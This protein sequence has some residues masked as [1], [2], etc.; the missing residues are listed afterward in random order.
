MQIGGKLNGTLYK[1]YPFL[2]SESWQHPRKPEKLLG[3]PIGDLGQLFGG[4][5]VEGGDHVG[6]AGNQP[7]V[8]DLSPMGDG[9][10]V[11]AIGLQQKS[12]Y[13]HRRHHRAYP[14]SVLKCGRPAEG[15]IPTPT[16][17]NFP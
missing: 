9:R 4:H 15:N 6:N 1:P 2:R 11:G 12:V 14:L 7:R 17:Q 8:V 16:S 10:H 5:A 3:V 13:I